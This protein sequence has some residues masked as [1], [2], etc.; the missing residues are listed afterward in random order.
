MITLS[1]IKAIVLEGKKRILKVEQFG[2]KT[3]VEVAPFGEDS[4]PLK[5]MTAI[6]SKTAESGEPIILG[7]INK[8]QVSKS[9]E[10]RLYSLNSDGSI[11]FYIHLKNDGTL[12]MGGD[13]DNLIKYT[14]L[15]TALK[16]Q[17]NLINIELGK[18]AIAITT[19]GG[20]YTPDTI[21]TDISQSKL[22]NIK[23]S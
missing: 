9:G 22:D 16:N 23:T 7:Y 4:S 20:M 3:A 18:I 2:A 21:N 5:N 1:K 15:D 10:K 19:L 13:S 14:P 12:E 11:S 8:N 6:Y 17:D